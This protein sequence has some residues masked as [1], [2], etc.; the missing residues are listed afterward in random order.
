[1]K[2]YQRYFNDDYMQYG[3]GITPDFSVSGRVSPYNHQQKVIERIK[4]TYCGC[5][6][7]VKDNYCD[8]CGAPLF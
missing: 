6:H 2:N 3:S 5:S 1:M 4:C 7:S 8:S